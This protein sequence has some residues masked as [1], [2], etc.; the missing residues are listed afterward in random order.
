MWIF[1]TI[2]VL[3]IIYFHFVLEISAKNLW[4]WVSKNPSLRAMKEIV[5]LMSVGLKSQVPHME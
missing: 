4:E 1:N 5:K 2:E 3:G